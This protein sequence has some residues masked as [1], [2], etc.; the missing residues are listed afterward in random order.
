MLS[1]THFD[2]LSQDV[3]DISCMNQSQNSNVV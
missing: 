3:W 2:S 1:C